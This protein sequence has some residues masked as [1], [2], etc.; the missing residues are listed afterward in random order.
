MKL[1]IFPQLI[2][3][4]NVYL[5]LCTTKNGSAKHENW[6]TIYLLSLLSK[7]LLVGERDEEGHMFSADHLAPHIIIINNVKS[8][9]AVTTNLTPVEHRKHRCSY[10]S[11]EYLLPCKR[12]IFATIEMK[13]FLKVRI[14][15]SQSQKKTKS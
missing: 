4:A 14:K 6:V 8:K 2:R 7:I 1:N 9:V 15:F 5:S 3:E 13:Y 11:F 10:I 12:F